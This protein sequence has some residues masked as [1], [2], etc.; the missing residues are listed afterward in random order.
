MFAEASDYPVVLNFDNI[1]MQD[2]RPDEYLMIYNFKDF[3][4]F[5][6]PYSQV[7]QILGL[8]PN[9][10]VLLGINGLLELSAQDNGSLML[11]QKRPFSQTLLPSLSLDN[12]KD[13][14]EKKPQ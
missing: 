5:H 4:Q 14:L 8:S 10:K 1:L 7:K 11:E 3:V 6:I 12:L 13:M 9:D 2:R